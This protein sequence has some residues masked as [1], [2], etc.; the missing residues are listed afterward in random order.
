MPKPR[1]PNIRLMKTIRVMSAAA[2]LL[3]TTTAVAQHKPSEVLS[4]FF[5]NHLDRILSPIGQPVP[6]PLPHARVT[7]L[8]EQFADQWS[9][10]PEADKPMYQAAVAVCDA[11]SSAMDERQKAIASLQGSRAVHGPSDL[12]ARRK[13][14]P[15]RGT[16]GDA[17]LAG[18]GLQREAYEEQ[19]RKQEAR[20]ND[21]FFNT[22]LET[23]WSHRTA[24]LRQNI[25]ALYARERESEREFTATADSS[26]RMGQVDDT[27]ALTPVGIWRWFTGADV[28]INQHGT[29]SGNRG[30]YG[31]WSWT[32]KEKREFTMIWGR[33]KFVDNLTL[34]SDGQEAV[35]KNNAG[36][37][38]TAERLK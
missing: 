19:N 31:T 15:T 22:Q 11:V 24:Q 30:G 20:Q 3:L 4:L 28:T 2:S 1:H 34:S 13:D 27:V 10:A 25:N 17:Q 38:V 33:K 32:N 23:N 8:R 36:V 21:N 35:G 37:S 7:Q 29:F 18:L 12:G 9:K 6:V 14:I 26:D 16:L 5:Q